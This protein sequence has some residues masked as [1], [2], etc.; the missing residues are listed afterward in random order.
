MQRLE[1]HRYTAEMR[2]ALVTLALVGIAAALPNDVDPDLRAVMTRHLHFTTTELSDLQ[3]GKVVKHSIDSGS[4]GEVAVTGAVLIHASKQVFLDRVR[5]ITQFKR[6]PDVLEIGKFSD[7]PV[8]QDLAPLTIDRDDFDV[9]ACRVRDCGIRLPAESIRR[10]QQDVPLSAPDAQGRAA[11][12]FKELIFEHVL[13]YERGETQGQMLQ[14]DDGDRPI[15]P[16]EEF[17]GVLRDTPALDAIEPGLAD[18]LRHYAASPLP[19][20][21]DFLYWS[22]ER[23]GIAPFIT[24]THVTIRCPSKQTCVT[25]TRD[26]YSSR[27]IDAS[28]AIA[29]ATDAEAAGDA[30]YLIYTNRSRANALKGGLAALRRALAGRRA[31]G[32]LEE[33]LKSIKNRLEGER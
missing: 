33:M 25:A 29:I 28:L 3:K 31:R 2:L 24:V 1:D 9:R 16:S 30:F 12:L 32:S 17:D 27:Y 5:D 7:P 18:H 19:N 22:K 8:L 6:G 13:A 26:V 10:F 21:E 14:Y 15:R 20:A 4:P 11:A 23:F